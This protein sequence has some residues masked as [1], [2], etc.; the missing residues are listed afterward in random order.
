MKNK[1]NHA[2]DSNFI[3]NVMN[4]I[5]ITDFYKINP[6]W[7]DIITYLVKRKSPFDE[8]ELIEECGKGITDDA[9][10]KSA[11]FEAIERYSAEMVK[12]EKKDLLKGT[13]TDLNSTYNLMNPAI[14]S[15]KTLEESPKHLNLEWCEG[16]DLLYDEKIFVP[17]D[18]VFFPYRSAFYLSH[19]V[20]LASGE[21]YEDAILHGLYEVIEHDTLNIYAYN[22]I[23]GRDIL[24]D[25]SDNTLFNICNTIT[26]AGI[27][28]S[29][30]FLP[31]D[32]H[33]PVT[34]VLFKHIPQM[35]GKKTAGLSCH[36]N[37]SI[38]LM[39]ALLECAQTTSFWYYKIQH[40]E[41]EEK[42]KH[43]PLYM[44]S[45]Y[46]KTKDCEIKLKDIKNTSKS[47]INRNI[48]EILKKI[49]KFATHVISIDIT[50][51]S[52]GVP[53]VRIVI[54]EFENTFTDK[55]ARG[56]TKIV[57]KALRS[58]FKSPST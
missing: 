1:M 42:S 21:T 24:V 13:F 22:A 54:P 45:L 49:R 5:N 55:V 44:N 26:A 23:P 8:N 35:P 57:Q 40:K 14:V 43:P 18:Y 28:F 46:R 7:I 27:T 2:S 52:L 12:K 10:K 33:I 56:R 32:M 3:E 51:D 29:M 58:Y 41:G 4:K 19:T 48:K 39:K 34:L 20:G 31:N 16:H 17:A 47:T 15:N 50:T 36:L 9:A 53:A 11:L 30:K 37:P 25:S 6:E 38:A